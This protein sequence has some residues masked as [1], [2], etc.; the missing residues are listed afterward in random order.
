MDSIPEST[1]SGRLMIIATAKIAPGQ[2]S[3]YEELAKQVKAHI[4][5]GKE[6]GTNFGFQLT[7]RVTRKLDAASKPTGEY[8]IIEEYTGVDYKSALV[9]HTQNPVTQE[10]LTSGIVAD[11]SIEVVDEF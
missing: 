4:D 5:A 10:I 6:P 1:S 11:A 2:E 9:K 8:I 3:R 7:Y